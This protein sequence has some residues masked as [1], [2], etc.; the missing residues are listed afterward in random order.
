MEKKAGYRTIT[1]RFR[2][3]CEPMELLAETKKIYNQVLSF[4]YGVLR[5]EPELFK[6]PKLKLLRQLELL[7]IGAQVASAEEVKYPIP[8]K[9]VPLYFRRAAINDAIR[10]YASFLSGEEQGARMAETFQTS[11]IMYKGMYKEFTADSIRLKLYNGESWKWVTCPVDTCGRQMPKEEQI[12]SPVIVLNQGRAMLHVP[13]KEAVEDVRTVE[14][15]MSDAR[16]ICAV[17][18][19]WGNTMAVA[20]VMTTQGEF[21]AS[22][23]I[24]GG[25]ELKHRKNLLLKRIDRNRASMG[26]NRRPLSQDENKF[27][28][29]KLRC[30]IDDTTHKISRELV[31][32]CTEWD[33]SF[34]VAPKNKNKYV[35]NNPDTAPMA[36][37]LSKENK[38]ISYFKYDKYDWLG[39][40]ITSYL[41]YKSF[42]EGIVTTTVAAK[43]SNTRCHICGAELKPTGSGENSSEFRCPAGHRGN[44]DFNT[45]V[46]LGK[47]FLESQRKIS[48]ELSL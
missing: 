17:T 44:A 12:M 29:E 28:K 34:I 9:K 5:Q 1:Y 35:K 20:V 42:G 38:K 6:T 36:G 13:V 7:T 19:P 37:V 31:D 48:Q 25:K 30:I 3:Y 14:Q 15:R 24:H 40:R 26:G 22:R 41:K 23:F 2:L 21:L 10:L 27:L 45:T 43:G 33:V 46:N 4:Y 39:R 18:F 16:R 8:Y 47:C 11:P 32:F